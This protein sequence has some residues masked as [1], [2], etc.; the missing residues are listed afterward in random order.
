MQTARSLRRWMALAS[1]ALML[2][3]LG[4][5]GVTRSSAPEGASTT[6]GVGLPPALNPPDTLP[7]TPPYTPPAILP[8]Q[9][10]SCDSVRAGEVGHITWRVGNDS[11]SL[12]TVQWTLTADG[13]WAGLPVSGSISVD[14]MSTVPLVTEIAVPTGTAPGFPEFELWVTRPGGV[15]PTSASGGLRVHP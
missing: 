15:A 14:P 13:S 2:S 12:F 3:A 9:Y 8:V 10:V 7:T 5:C 6:R 11:S 1:G 4:G